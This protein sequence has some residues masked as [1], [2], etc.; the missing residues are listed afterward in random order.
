MG[1]TQSTAPSPRAVDDLRGTFKR[2]APL[3]RDTARFTRLL[4][5]RQRNITRAVHNLQLVAGSLGSV[6]TQFASL[7]R[8]SNTNFGAISSQDA[9]L[10]TALTLLPPTLQ[11]TTQTLAKVQGFATKA[12]RR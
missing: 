5:Q 7:I 2:F 6:E 8:A 1:G 12:A 3:N 9:N 11:T 4:A 10:R